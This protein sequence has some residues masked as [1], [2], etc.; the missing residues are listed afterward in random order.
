MVRVLTFDSITFCTDGAYQS[1]FD[2]HAYTEAEI[3]AEEWPTEGGVEG[4]E[5][6]GYHGE[7]GRFF[8]SAS[9]AWLSTSSTETTVALLW[10]P[11]GAWVWYSEDPAYFWNEETNAYDWVSQDVAE[12]QYEAT[13]DWAETDDEVKRNPN[14]NPGP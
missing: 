7:S 12:E 1:D 5:A 10:K 3:N 6:W 11:K 14:P 4:D 8:A 9:I 13:M 2:A